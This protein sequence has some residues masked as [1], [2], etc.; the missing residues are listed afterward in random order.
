MRNI[1]TMEELMKAFSIKTYFLEY[2]SVTTKIK[3]FLEWRKIPLYAELFPRNRSL[4]VLLDQSEKGRSKLT[5]GM[6]D[7]FEH[8]LE[9]VVKW[10]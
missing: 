3:R 6:R 5:T 7:S 8:V 4:N 2:N 9:N 10:K 1:V